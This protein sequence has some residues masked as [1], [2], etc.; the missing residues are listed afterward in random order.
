M[1]KYLCIDNLCVDGK[2][3]AL[4]GCYYTVESCA[5]YGEGFI[6]YNTMNSDRVWMF[7]GDFEKHFVQF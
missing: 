2:L 4:A 6:V 7:S 3:E 5:P 1:N